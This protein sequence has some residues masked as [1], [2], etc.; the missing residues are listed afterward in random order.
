MFTREELETKSLLELRL[1]DI[2]TPEDEKL[3]QEFVRELEKELPPVVPIYKGDVPDIKTPEEEK[4]WQ[5]V[6]DA[7]AKIN[8][9]IQGVDTSEPPVD[10]VEETVEKPVEALV[11][12]SQENS[13]PE[14][15]SEVVPEVT[16]ETVS[17]VAE[18]VVQEKSPFCDECTSKG[19]RHLKTCSKF[20]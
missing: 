16:P 8:K 18:D 7:R 17:E 13:V 12:A 19:G 2:Q 6:L 1:L 9:E 10:K 5:E 15:L 3:V 14:T 4:K 20:K 11:E